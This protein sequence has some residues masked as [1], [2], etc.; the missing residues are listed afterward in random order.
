MSDDENGSLFLVND[1]AFQWIV[2]SSIVSFCGGGGGSCG[3]CGGVVVVILLVV[4]L[5]VVLLV[6]GV[7]YGVIVVVVFQWT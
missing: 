6:E 1:P 4:V 3:C 7:S 2:S 5:A